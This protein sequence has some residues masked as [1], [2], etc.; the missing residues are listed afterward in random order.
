[1]SDRWFV[2]LDG[3]LVLPITRYVFVFRDPDTP[4]H[5]VPPIA[6]AGSARVGYNF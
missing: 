6:G 3:S 5:T 2:D 1:V 4:V